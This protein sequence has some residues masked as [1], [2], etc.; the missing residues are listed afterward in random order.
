[1]NYKLGT[2]VKDVL[3]G[4]TGKI[5]TKQISLYAPSS[6]LVEP[7]NTLKDG[8]PVYGQ[9]FFEKRLTEMEDNK[10]IGY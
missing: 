3:S 5:T 8:K 6:Y 2:K 1:M 4:F 9:W 7:E 10:P